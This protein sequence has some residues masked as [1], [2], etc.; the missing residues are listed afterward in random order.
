MIDGNC[1]AKITD[2]GFSYLKP[3][4]EDSNQWRW[5]APER[6][7]SASKRKENRDFSFI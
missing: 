2:F 6:L 1:T 3:H 7:L 4:N 5:E